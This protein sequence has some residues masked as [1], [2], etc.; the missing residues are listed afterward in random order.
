MS[1][2]AADKNAYATENLAL[3][4]QLKEQIQKLS[5][6]TEPTDGP[7]SATSIQGALRE[8]KFSIEL[9]QSLDQV[10]QRDDQLLRAR[11]LLIAFARRRT[12]PSKPGIPDD[13]DEETYLALYPD[14]AAYVAAG[15]FR[16]GYDHWL[17]VG[18]K[19]GRIATYTTAP[20]IPADFD[21]AG[22]LALN[23]DVSEDVRAGL[24]ASGY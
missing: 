12:L 16:S 5:G 9:L 13:F 11:E 1:A 24:Y 20:G 4:R 22:Y 8:L 2:D 15:T 17:T 6:K 10:S 14:V 23:P 3:S 7:R 19:E 18:E 21:E